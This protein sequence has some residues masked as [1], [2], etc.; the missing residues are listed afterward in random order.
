MTLGEHVWERVSGRQWK[1]RGID[2]R[3]SPR[4]GASAWISLVHWTGTRPHYDWWGNGA[5][6]C[7]E[8]TLGGSWHISDNV[9]HIPV[10]CGRCSRTVTRGLEI[11]ALDDVSTRSLVVS[12]VDLLHRS[13]VLDLRMGT[14]QG[15][16]SWDSALV[17]EIWWGSVLVGCGSNHQ[18]LCYILYVD[19]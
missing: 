8:M 10:W 11:R 7:F 14:V 2:E 5:L 9:G 15:I 18:S 17:M 4:T 16:Y 19:Q 12:G 1:E 3:I 13:N 6:T